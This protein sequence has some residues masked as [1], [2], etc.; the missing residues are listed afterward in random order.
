MCGGSLASV[1]RDA[2]VLTVYLVGALALTTLTARWARVR[3]P[4]RVKPEL[5]L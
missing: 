4:S 5:V 1:G 2:A 3:T